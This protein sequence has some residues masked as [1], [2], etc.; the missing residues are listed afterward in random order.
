MAWFCIQKGLKF[1]QTV[2][3]RALRALCFL[4]ESSK[5]L[6][7]Q[8]RKAQ[9]KVVRR[10]MMSAEFGTWRLTIRLEKC[11]LNAKRAS[12]SWFSPG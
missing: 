1:L 9:G 11:I 6:G 2:K 12:M 8:W 10:P 3:F 4:V 5:T 7:I